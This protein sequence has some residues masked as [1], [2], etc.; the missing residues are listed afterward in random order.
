M[1]HNLWLTACIFAQD[2]FQDLCETKTFVP[3]SVV[4]FKQMLAWTILAWGPFGTEM[5]SLKNFDFSSY[6]R[7]KVC[8]EDFC[9]GFILFNSSFVSEGNQN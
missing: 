4:P 8:D 9:A 7:S 5:R 2:K 1:L 3:Y 6:L